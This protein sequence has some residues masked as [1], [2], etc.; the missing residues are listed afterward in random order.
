MPPKIKPTMVLLH[1]AGA[2][3]W[4]WDRMRSYLHA[5]SIALTYPGRQGKAT[6]ETCAEAV[7]AELSRTASAN[8]STQTMGDFILVLHSLAGVLAGPLATRLGARLKK[9]VLLSAIVPSPG[10]TFAQAL[11]FPA[12]WVLPLL[13]RL[14]AKGLKPSPQM[15]RSELCQ[16]LQ[17][18]DAEKVVSQ[19]EAEF[20]GLYLTP[21]QS[22][23]IDTPL[24]YI[25]LLQDRSISP[26]LQQNVI[27]QLSINSTFEVDAGHLAMLSQPERLAGILNSLCEQE[28]AS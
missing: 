3:P 26:R 10:Q 6:P 21:R 19:Y 22:I 23:A 4:I 25:Q 7:A 24:A 15:I 11:G 2:G 18:E 9:V 16:D 13:F 28:T 27:R 8:T 1:G 20:P 17:P 14:H 5:D 12:R